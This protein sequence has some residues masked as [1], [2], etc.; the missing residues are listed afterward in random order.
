MVTSQRPAAMEPKRRRTDVRGLGEVLHTGRISMAGLRQL[1]TT[2]ADSGLEPGRLSRATFQSVN[3]D[4]FE[5]YKVV[6]SVPLEGDGGEFEW[7]YLDPNSWMA[8]LISHSP[9]LQG[10]FAEA[11]HRSP[12]TFEQPWRL[13][14][15]FDEFAP[16]NK[17]N[18]DNRRK[19]MVLSFTFA[20]LGQDAISC[21]FG[22]FTVA[23]VRTTVLEKARGGWSALLR[24]FVERQLLAADGLATT[25]CPVTIAGQHVPIFARL[26]NLLSDGDGLRQAL[27]WRGASSLKPC[28][29]H[30]NVFKKAGR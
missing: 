29:K 16:G 12:C 13:V 28:F 19:M 26:T 14:L 21:G 7:E 18:F 9:G 5:R 15:G 30:Y 25:G 1:L 4:L 10:L 3:W 17:L 2:I 23:V 6:E 22:W 11:L 20:E 8:A 27:D 24:R